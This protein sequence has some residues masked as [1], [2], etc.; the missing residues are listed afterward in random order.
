MLEISIIQ[1]LP[2]SVTWWKPP[3]YLWI[4]MRHP[5]EAPGL[6]MNEHDTF[7]SFRR[8]PPNNGDNNSD[9]PHLQKATHKV[10]HATK[11]LHAMEEQINGS[12]DV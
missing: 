8:I 11:V 1:H 5:L 6:K 3:H 9:P 4:S 10:L 7:K 2:A 12:F